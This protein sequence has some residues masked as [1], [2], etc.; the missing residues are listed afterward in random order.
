MR[1]KR[2]LFVAPRFV[3][4]KR[5]LGAFAAVAAISCARVQP[6]IVM[7]AVTPI[8]APSVDAPG[9]NGQRPSSDN[10]VVGILTSGSSRSAARKSS[11]KKP[12]AR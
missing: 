6:V 12:S 5:V 3:R 8:A 10:A 1:P 7:T 4:P 9:A 11:T 2:V